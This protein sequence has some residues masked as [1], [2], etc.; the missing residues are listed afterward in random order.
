[1]GYIKPKAL[2]VCCTLILP[3]YKNF[4][5]TKIT[6]RRRKTRFV[7]VYFSQKHLKIAP[8]YVQGGAIAFADYLS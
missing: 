7:F 3:Q 5:N 6:V 8:P 1:M 2:S 4:F